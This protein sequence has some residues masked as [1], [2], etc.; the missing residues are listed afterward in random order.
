MQFILNL[1]NQE[2][3]ILFSLIEKEITMLQGMEIEQNLFLLKIKNY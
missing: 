3:R 1:V 2:E